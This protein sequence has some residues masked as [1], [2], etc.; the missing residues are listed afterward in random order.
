M[1]SLLPSCLASYQQLTKI[2]CKVSIAKDCLPESSAGGVELSSRDGRIKVIN[3][4]E[5]RLDQIS[6]QMM[7]QLREILFGVNDNRK[8]RD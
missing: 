7:P 4:L 5:S 6:E 3:T 8:F 2:N 1:Q